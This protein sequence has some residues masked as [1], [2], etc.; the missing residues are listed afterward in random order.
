MSNSIFCPNCGMLKRNCVCGTY[1]A[2][3]TK[4]PYVSK[5]KKNSET[6]SSKRNNLKAKS[7]SKKLILKI[8][9]V[10]KGIIPIKE[11]KP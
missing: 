2:D 10:P 7:S 3:R 8:I 9:I 6:S 1:V 5:K 4:K 11:R